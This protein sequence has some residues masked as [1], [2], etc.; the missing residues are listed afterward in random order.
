MSPGIVTD[1]GDS[2]S[3][4]GLKASVFAILVPGLC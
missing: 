2:A 4:T 3:G 1:K